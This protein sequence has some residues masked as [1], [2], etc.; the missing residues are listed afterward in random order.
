LP[1]SLDLFPEL[2][3][4]AGDQFSYVFDDLLDRADR[5]FADQPDCLG[6]HPL[7]GDAKHVEHQLED[8]R[9]AEIARQGDAHRCQRTEQPLHETGLEVRPDVADESL[10]TTFDGGDQVT[11]EGDWIV[12]DA[13]DRI[14]ALLQDG[15]QLGLEFEQ[16]LDH[17]AELFGELLQQ[18]LV[19]VLHRLQRFVGRRR[20]LYFCARLARVLPSGVDACESCCARRP[21]RRM[22]PA[23]LRWP[24]GWRRRPIFAFPCRLLALACATRKPDEIGTRRSGDPLPPGR[25]AAPDRTLTFRQAERLVAQPARGPARNRQ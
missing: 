13:L 7:V 8:R 18:A 19:L 25:P 1:R 14:L 11:E 16:C 24:A 21:P 4:P 17:F 2:R 12:E 10:E 9:Q 22:S 15:H 6:A 23:A 3:R 20:P 5:A